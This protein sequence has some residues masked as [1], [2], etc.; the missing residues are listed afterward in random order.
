MDPRTMIDIQTWMRSFARREE[1]AE[2]AMVMA[3]AINGDLVAREE[4]ST[5]D[6]ATFDIIR[7]MICYP[8]G[9][10]VR[11]YARS[12]IAK[13]D[14]GSFDSIWVTSSIRDDGEEMAFLRARCRAKGKRESQTCIRMGLG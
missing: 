6:G 3:W 1:P 12:H 9:T 10:T 14:E 7:R 8:N 11:I 4:V 13:M 2:L 5:Y